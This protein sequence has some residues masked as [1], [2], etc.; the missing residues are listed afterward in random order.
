[1]AAR[2]SKRSVIVDG[3]RMAR[4]RR[5]AGLTQ[6]ALAE[7][8]TGPH[9]LGLSSIKRAERGQ[10]VDLSTAATISHLL[11]V[12]LRELVKQA[13]D[14]SWLPK[15]T[16]TVTRLRSLGSDPEQSHTA[17]GFGVELKVRLH[18]LWFPVVAS[19]APLNAE[20][21]APGV[22][23]HDLGTHYLVSGT[24]ADRDGEL[25]V[26]VEVTD[27]GSKQL[28][29][30]NSYVRA[31]S[32]MFELQ[33]EIATSI[34]SELN[35][36]L[37][38][39]EAAKLEGYAPKDLNA[40][41]QGIAGA[42]HFYRRSPQDNTTARGLLGAALKRDRSMP[43]AWYCLALTHQQDLVNQW[44]EN[45]RAS[46][47]ALSEVC[48]E[49]ERHYRDEPWS[50]IASA[51]VDIYLGER[52]RAE[53]RLVSAIDS[54][55]NISHAYALY[56]QT[57]AMRQEPEAALV[58]FDT[59]LRFGPRDADR[60]TIHTGIALTHFAGENYT[61]AIE[62]ATRASSVR[63]D[64]A[65][66]YGTAAAAHALLGNDEPARQAIDRMRRFAP[67]S[68]LAGLEAIVAS[69]NKDIAQRY[70]E[71]LKRAGLSN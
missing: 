24:L 35:Q 11:K 70:L 19:E 59:A 48:H 26:S 69:T 21:L 7:L 2:V 37:V 28:R 10:A 13:I 33:R 25:R 66:P 38:N 41:Q 44:T 39:L 14:P 55:P 27:L 29:W 6:E 43:L 1:M 68:T 64:A 61:A 56:G 30:A 60:W 8:A 58:Q 46:I 45:S 22:A 32:K 18:R 67:R 42:W 17:D 53:D 23:E 71:G 47:G 15:P 5:E 51:Y 16:L 36:G 3:E 31:H 52:A 57:L 4:A 40:W 9:C 20:E 50:Q 54:D 12:P 62:A 63:P 65:F 49:F 34:A